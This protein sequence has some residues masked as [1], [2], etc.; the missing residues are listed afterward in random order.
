MAKRI[1]IALSYTY[2]ELWIGGSYYIENLINALDTLPD[3]EKPH[4]VILAANQTDVRVAQNKLSYPYISFQLSSGESNRLFRFV[5]K[6]ANRLLKTTV[7]NQKIKGLDAAFPYYECVQQ[8]LATKKIYW[9]A[10][11]QESFAPEFFTAEAID[12]IKKHQHTIQSS[13]ETLIL[14]SEDALAHFKALYPGH[15]VKLHVL[16]FAVTHPPYQQLDIA[17]LLHKHQLPT[18]F[19]ICPNQFWKHKNQLTVLKAVDKLKKQ[20]TEI[21]VAFT[22]KTIDYRHP[23]YFASLEKYV[24]D[25]DMAGNIKFLGFIDR[26]EQLKLMAESIAIIQPSFFEGWSTVVEDAKA[27]NKALIASA[28]NVHQ[29]QLAGSSAQFFAPNDMDEL[30]NLLNK[31]TNEPALPPLYKSDAYQSHIEKFGRNFLI[32]CKS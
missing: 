11:F 9:I 23:D 26:K 21:M 32:V 25:N 17:S 8:S 5:N 15:T 16:P 27:M 19:F 1:R 12:T 10:D 31:A 14:S 2:N 22:G 20:G 7:F 28:I 6:V 4:I 13:A 30:V 24:A 3:A 29:E 18:R